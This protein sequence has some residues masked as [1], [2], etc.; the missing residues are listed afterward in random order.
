MIFSLRSRSD[1]TL[2]EVGHHT[3][4]AC[5]YQGLKERLEQDPLLTQE[6]KQKDIYKSKWKA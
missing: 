6:F 5:V 2:V 4:E 1:V 3:M